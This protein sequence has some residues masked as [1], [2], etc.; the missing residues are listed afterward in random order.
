V[1]ATLVDWSLLG[2]AALSSF[3]IGLGVLVVTAIAVAAS[4]RAQESRGSGNERAFVGFGAVTV[5]AVAV[6]LGAV[7]GGIW[8][9][10][11]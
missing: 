1:I 8:V 9:M 3:V 10:T 11:R 2:Q 7:A 6:L 4:L 5:L